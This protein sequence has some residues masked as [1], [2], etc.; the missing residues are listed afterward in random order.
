MK[1]PKPSYETMEKIIEVLRYGS[2]AKGCVP[3]KSAHVS[4]V[5]YANI[6]EAGMEF[7]EDV[8]KSGVKV[9]VATTT[10]P[11]CAEIGARS[12]RYGLDKE[13]IENQRRIVRALEKI[14]AEAT[15]TCTPYECRRVGFGEH[16]A[17]AESSAV[18]YANSVLG[19]RSNRESG[20]SALASAVTGKTPLYGMHVAKNRVP[21]ARVEVEAGELDE[22]RMGA[23]G[24]LLGAKLGSEVAFLSGVGRCD[25]TKIKC[26]LAAASTAAP[27][28]LVHVE[29]VT[30]EEEWAGKLAPR[31][32][33]HTIGMEEIEEQ[34]EKLSFDSADP[35]CALIGCP[36]L[37]LEELARLAEENSGRKFGK[38]AFLFTSRR[39]AELARRKGYAGKLE[40][41]GASILVDTCV[42]W[43]GLGRLGLERPATNSAKACFYLRNAMGLK[44]KLCS[45]RDC[46]GA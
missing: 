7:L 27:V 36:H 12:N 46:L 41:S 31:R 14:G 38:P 8:A 30:A 2:G 4:G 3:I 16:V 6:K 25:K 10:N 5:S 45:A 28:S 21:K 29:G 22:A 40:R 37:S 13:L 35:D 20:I 26:L 24:Y 39:V 42:M 15:L 19:A 33:E 32:A 17:W 1:V 23:L 18:A 43:S 34:R 9:K 11:G 44:P